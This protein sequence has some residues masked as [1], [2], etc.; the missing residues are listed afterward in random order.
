MNCS[1]QW[2][3]TDM[4]RINRIRLINYGW[5]SR[6]IDDLVLDFHGG[7]NTEIR[8][9]NG[10]G[11]SVLQRLIYQAIFPNTTISGNRIEDYLK[12]KPAMTVIEWLSDSTGTVPERTTTGVLLYKSDTKE[13]SNSNVHFF[14]FLSNDSKH[15][16]LDN[17]PNVTSEAGIVEIE[18]Y[19]V[20]QNR[21]RTLANN[22]AEIFYF[23]SEN[24][25][26]YHQRLEEFGI[27]TNN[28][29]EVIFQ[30]ISSEDPFAAFLKT[31]KTTDQLI[32][33]YLLPNIER[34]LSRNSDN[35]TALRTQLSEAVETMSLKKETKDLRDLLAEYIE[36]Y[37]EQAR[38]LE[39]VL[40]EKQ[41]Q[42]V[43]AAK[44]DG[45]HRALAE[46]K[47]ALEEIRQ[48]LEETQKA[49]EEDL[50]RIIREERSLE[51]YRARE[52][53]EQALRQ[54][55]EQTALRKKAEET[56]TET[57]RSRSMLYARKTL[58]EIRSLRGE[59][60]ALEA[61]YDGLDQSEK[62]ILLARTSATL[63]ARYQEELV[64]L[65]AGIT[66]KTEAR[67]GLRKELEELKAGKKQIEQRR[68]TLAKKSGQLK[69][70]KA[71]A[72]KE[73]AALFAELQ[74]EPLRRDFLER[75]LSEDVDAL[76]NILNSRI[77]ECEAQLSRLNR[78]ISDLRT[79]NERLRQEEDRLREQLPEMKNALQEAK[80]DLKKFRFL[81][82][83][84]KKE[85]E[86]YAV[87]DRFLYDPDV[88]KNEY[89]IRMRRNTDERNRISWQIRQK[90]ELIT[91]A[92]NGSV[93][94]PERV[95]ALLEA[96]GIAFQT[97][98]NFLSEQR[99][100]DR[101]RL[102]AGAPLLP[103][104]ILADQASYEKLMKLDLA[105][106][107]IRQIIPIYIYHELETPADGHGRYL[108]QAR[109]ELLDAKKKADYLNV[110]T[111]QIRNDQA[112]LN[113]IETETGN[114]SSFLAAI[115]AF[116]YS[117]GWESGQ[118]ERIESLSD[119]IRTAEERLTAVRADIKDN[120]HASDTAN[121][122]LVD[123]EI[124]LRTRQDQ[125]KRFEAYLEHS[126]PAYQIILHELAKLSA[127][128]TKL[129]A[130]YRKTEEEL[131]KHNS[132]IHELSRIIQNE[133]S[134]RANTERERDSYR[135]SDSAEL[136]EESTEE[137]KAE[138]AQ[139][140]AETSE[141]TQTL[142]AQIRRLK[143]QEREKQEEFDTHSVPADAL[144][145]VRWSSE[146]A[147]R[148]NGA[149]AEMEAGLKAI[150]QKERDAGNSAA[151]ANVYFEEAQKKLEAEGLK[152]PLAP[153]EIRMNFDVRKAENR[154]AKAEA[155]RKLSEAGSLSVK[156]EA[157]LASV[158]ALHVKPETE[159]EC[160]ELAEDFRTQYEEMKAEY[161]RTSDELSERI[162]TYLNAYRTV[163]DRY[164]GKNRI[165]E[166]VYTQSPPFEGVRDIALREVQDW[167]E[168]CRMKVGTLEKTRDMY[169]SDL[170][171]LEN[172]M[173]Q[174]VNSAENYTKRVC[175]SLRRISK[176]SQMKI[177]DKVTPVRLLR[178]ELND[179]LP[180]SPQ[181]LEKYLRDGIRRLVNLYDEKSSDLK[182]EEDSLL[183][184]RRMMNVYLEQTV[185]PV[186]VY[187][188]DENSSHSGLVDWDKA[189]KS[190]SSGEHS[191]SCF[192][193]IAAMLAYTR[194][195]DSDLSDLKMR[196]YEPII[197]D[198]PFAAISS[199]YLVKPIITI[200]DHLHL[201]L[202]TFTHSTQQSIANSFDVVIQLRNTALRSGKNR[203]D[204]DKERVLEEKME[205]ASLFSDSKQLSFF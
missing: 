3:E 118:E 28:W 99:T 74:A 25:R 42:N 154:S 76:R 61:Q 19:S 181:R 125:R 35:K 178:I 109:E 15:L 119:E 167:R 62:S 82:Q 69:Q 13:D 152:E 138:F 85:M 45:F 96:H 51:Y 182:K 112:R 59:I 43:S 162:K 174:F 68:F 148:L 130:Q 145:T 146:E 9:G 10:G 201:Q 198:N 49:L 41:K 159:A 156:A 175:D 2:R 124:Q 38:L 194:G 67:N 4:P 58:D 143:G 116:S 73:E 191:T 27:S 102:L 137:L 199:E 30:M 95:T 139:L 6:R 172:M 89:D 184:S 22:Y 107:L 80:A 153:E 133:E 1:R 115:S 66:E 21:Y 169:D 164:Y 88:L 44:M 72:E 5:A 16:S 8:L 173:R 90:Q 63:Y 183:N 40:E 171:N 203:I 187:R 186:K 158:S 161:E 195:E 18:A 100:K 57:L 53:H 93:Y 179:E 163:K 185:I 168:T 127:E 48:E 157:V 17:L 26:N 189:A 150:R 126:E 65:E 101:K 170:Q 177:A 131:E 39:D 106:E 98:E 34:H 47:T 180:D 200:V 32:N 86:R 36:Q 103:F 160:I 78:Q 75:L 29:K 31:S 193:I 113:E 46:R 37:E 114:L 192:V 81:R 84:L 52:G 60:S 140:S 20:S 108:Y 142:A 123:T 14:T 141:T 97:G 110:I 56:R 87:S 83:E 147:H 120:I 24:R 134:R 165:F 196:R 151:K 7:L 91:S 135:A 202:I 205:H 122:Q 132:T 129:E 23:A 149:L 12:D 55:E 104:A 117:S 166:K 128:E 111:E 144:E 64:R 204:V 155:Q 188:F 54:F 92:E 77:G 33:G 70:Q 136:R 11:K 71:Q 121:R 197:C 105:D 50:Y 79:E 176:Q 94:I 190:N